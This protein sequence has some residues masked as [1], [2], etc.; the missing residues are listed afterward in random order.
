M[1]EETTIDIE[2]VDMNDDARW[3][4]MF[5]NNTKFFPDWGSMIGFL[6]QIRNLKG[7]K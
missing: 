6:I 2:Y 3:M 5:G 7:W 4:V 1:D